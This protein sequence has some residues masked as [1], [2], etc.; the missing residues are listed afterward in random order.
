MR[1]VHLLSNIYISIFVHYR[2]LVHEGNVVTDN[3]R[4]EGKCIIRPRLL[5]HCLSALTRNAHKIGIQST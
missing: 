4:A 3:A 5:L 1:L 2:L